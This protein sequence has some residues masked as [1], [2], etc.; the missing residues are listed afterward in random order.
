MTFDDTGW[1]LNEEHGYAG[2]LDLVM[3]IGGRVGIIDIKTS[4]SIYKSHELQV[5]AYR[6]CFKTLKIDFTAILQVGTRSKAGYKLTE[7]QDC[8]DLFL[9]TMNIWR[10]ETEG[11]RPFQAEYPLTTK[12]T[13]ILTKKE[14]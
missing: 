6:H 13:D 11:Q 10:V 7:T 1:H 8:F 12:L 14:G 9:A 3:N 5:S 4:R 2:T